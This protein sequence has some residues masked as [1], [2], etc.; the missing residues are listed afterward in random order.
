VASAGLWKKIAS[1]LLLVCFVLPLSK[2]SMV[3]KAEPVV[4]IVADQPGAVPTPSVPHSPPVVFYGY[5]VLG[6]GVGD[7]AEGKF[8][9][10][11]FLCLWAVAFFAPAASLLIR[12]PWR[13]GIQFFAAF[14][15]LFVLQVVVFIQTPLFGGLLALACWSVLLILS[16]ATLWISFRERK[17]HG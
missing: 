5:E 10:I 4:G 1:L 9:D 12:E 15:S 8:K 6:A 16:S 17:V 11:P 13:S 2:C 3:K 7:V 14:P